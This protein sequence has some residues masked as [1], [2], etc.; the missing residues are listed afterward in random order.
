VEIVRGVRRRLRAVASAIAGGFRG[1]VTLMAFTD[2]GW[3]RQFRFSKRLAVLSCLLV[4]V[5]AVASTMAVVNLVRGG[6]HTTRMRSL[7]QQNQS[8][9]SLLQIQAEQLSTL[10]LEMDR[11]REFEESLRQVSGL[12]D[13]S[14]VR[15]DQPQVPRSESAPVPQRP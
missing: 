14:R 7:E 13:R 12:S 5:M 1:T 6:Y 4:L 15:Q 10:R 9:A 2:T 11:L 3:M 8:M